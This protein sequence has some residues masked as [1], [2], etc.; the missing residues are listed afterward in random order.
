[1][2]HPGRFILMGAF[3]ALWGAWAW[4]KGFWF[5]GRR[6]T[7]PVAKL[8]AFAVSVTGVFLLGWVFT[9]WPH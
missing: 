5:R 3:A 6:V 4:R 2:E 8:T 7:G 1:M 9:H